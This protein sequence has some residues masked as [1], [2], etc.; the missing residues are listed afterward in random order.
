MKI[1]KN[2]LNI[3]LSFLLIFVIAIIIVS[4]VLETKILDR[5]YVDSKLDETEFYLQVSREVKSG[6]ENYIYQSGLPVETFDNLFTDEMIKKDVSSIMDCLYNGTEISLSD[7]VVRK[8]LDIK[9]Q[10]YINSQGQEL[11]TQGKENIKKFEDLIVKEYRENVNT[12]TTL[13]KTGNQVLNNVKQV[14][15]MIGNK[16]IIILVI[17]IVSIIIINNKNLLNAINFISISFLSLGIL[18]KLTVNLIFKS[19]EFDNLVLL[20]T[21]LTNLIVSIAKEILYNLSDKGTLF[22][23]CSLIGIIV[24]A[25]LDNI[26]NEDNKNV[27]KAPKRRNQKRNI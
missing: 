23:V 19:I 4:N 10:N 5:N 11:N 24:C 9:V 8:N 12:S 3:I 20:T 15:E 25:I 7:E 22:I 21:S 18:L 27:V 14:N 1:I 17:I 16:P 26:N 6:F 2:I 13:Y